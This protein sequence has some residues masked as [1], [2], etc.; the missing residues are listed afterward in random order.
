MQLRQLL[1]SA[2][3]SN[4]NL[5]IVSFASALALYSLVHGRELCN[6]FSELNDPDDQAERFRAQLG[7]R[8]RGDEEAMDFDADYIR[9]LSYGMPPTAGLRGH[10]ARGDPEDD[11]SL[12]HI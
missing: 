12:I 8:E 5:K 1:R 9:A 2:L 10:R 11:L 4:L 6:A 3:A 7:N